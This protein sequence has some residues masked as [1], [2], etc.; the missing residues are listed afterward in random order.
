MLI[1]NH[2]SFRFILK[3]TERNIK[4]TVSVNALQLTNILRDVRNDAER[5]RVYLPKS[6]LDRFGVTE[7]DILKGRYTEAYEQLAKSVAGRA[8]HH[9]AAARTILPPEDRKAMASAELMGSV[10]WGLL[11]KLEA[12]RF[13]VFQESKTRLTKPHKAFLIARTWFRIW[14]GGMSANYGT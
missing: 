14:R 6:E 8:R 9:Y 1:N 3:I 12:K 4:K 7:V 5:G 13:N 10:Y 2:Q 11:R